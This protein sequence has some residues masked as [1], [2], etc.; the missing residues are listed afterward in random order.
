[1]CVRALRVCV[2]VCV[3]VCVWCV[4][5]RGFVSQHSRKLAWPYME[6]VETLIVSYSNW[7][8]KEV[9]INICMTN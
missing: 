7:R 2:C 3:C 4:Y 1:M 9:Y 6:I 5:E 8:T